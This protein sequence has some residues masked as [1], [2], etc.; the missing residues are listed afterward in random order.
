MGGEGCPDG[1][2]TAGEVRGAGAELVGAGLGESE[3]GGILVAVPGFGGIGL[4]GCGLEEAV[5]FRVGSVEFVCD[6]GVVV[7]ACLIGAVGVV[8]WGAGFRDFGC[9][10]YG[11][12][13]GGVGLGDMDFESGGLS[14]GPGG[15]AGL[16]ERGGSLFG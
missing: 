14:I 5:V 9:G 8:D 2:G 1:G 6:C 13:D 16:V 12:G 3:P 7:D 10:G 4:V 11:A 15:G